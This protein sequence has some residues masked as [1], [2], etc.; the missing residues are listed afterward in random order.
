MIL[1]SKSPPLFFSRKIDK[2]QNEFA[3][4]MDEE[5]SYLFLEYLSRSIKCNNCNER[6]YSNVG[7]GM[8]R[9]EG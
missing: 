6:F 1:N 5:Q 8:H 4:R 9:C 3:S 7:Y 2:A